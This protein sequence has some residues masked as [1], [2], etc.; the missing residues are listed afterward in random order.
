MKRD[1]KIE[2]MAT[3]HSEISYAYRLF[4]GM[5]KD[6][7]S[8]IYRGVFSQNITD[9]I[10]TLTESNLDKSGEDS[11]IKKRVFTIMVEGLQNITRHQEMEESS[12]VKETGIFLIQDVDNRYY[13]TTGNPILKRNIPNLTEQLNKINSLDNEELK[14]YYKRVLNDNII[15]DK[16][17][18]GLGLIEMARK[19]GNKLVYDFVDLND[20][21][22]YFYLNTEISQNETEHSPEVHKATHALENIKVIHRL[23]NQEDVVLIFNGIFNQESLLN[24][25]SIMENQMMEHNLNLKKKVFNIM[26]EM[27]QN[28]VKHGANSLD[29]NLNPGIF[30][31]NQK[32]K[33]YHL[34][35]GNYIYKSEV[36]NLKKKINYVN[37][38]SMDE[39][40]TF[41]EK[42]LFNFQIDTSKEAGLGLIE[43]RLK[44]NRKLTFEI[45]DF[46]EKFSFFVLQTVVD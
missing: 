34:N 20:N 26:V 25:L 37:S 5:Q 1:N 23:L 40:N 10:L 9:G 13:I 42:S 36:E 12:D 19:S 18:A 22:S 7:L 33:Q 45:N 4:E 21:Y 44:T 43:L 27:L 8:Y 32:G 17:G 16:G 29:N 3:Q 24:L 39:L 15:S 28:I 6:N 41:Y 2:L 38:L 35:T 46:N 11:K 31:I 14:N 30:F